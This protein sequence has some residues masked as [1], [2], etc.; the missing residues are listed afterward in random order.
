VDDL[1]AC[2]A[3]LKDR[4]DILFRLYGENRHPPEY[5]KSF[6]GRVGALLGMTHDVESRL[7]EIIA[8]ESL[9]DTVQ[10]M[11]HVPAEAGVFDTTDVVIFPSRL[12]GVGRSVFEGGVHGIPS[13]V[14]LKD[15][16]EDIVEDGVTGII[17]PEQDAKAMA[18]AVKKLA[19]DAAL[20]NK[21]GAAA[22][23]KYRAQFDPK[24]SAG[25]IV[26]IY[27]EVLARKR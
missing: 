5:Y 21:L 15:K 14:A 17:V 25:E 10:L 24:R 26:K 19:E 13:V 2:A 16:V 22:K 11:G 20:R 9:Q 3:L 7:R 1:L 8:R 12:N 27:R 18:E 23:L 6:R 4:K